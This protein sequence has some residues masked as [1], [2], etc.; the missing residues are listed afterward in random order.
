M[1]REAGWS[2]EDH[3]QTMWLGLN[4]YAY[5]LKILNKSEEIIS[6]ALAV[7]TVLGDA[8]YAVIAPEF[9][10]KLE[11]AELGLTLGK[12]DVENPALVSGLSVGNESRHTESDQMMIDYYAKKNA[13]AM[14][15]KTDLMTIAMGVA[16]GVVL[17]VLLVNFKVIH[18]A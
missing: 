9:R 15:K 17:G 16:I 5:T 11:S 3:P 13:D 12:E 2:D 1:K 4:A 7:K 14:K 6:L 10:Q 8:V 18:L